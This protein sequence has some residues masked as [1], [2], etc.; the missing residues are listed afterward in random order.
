MPVGSPVDVVIAAAVPVPD[1]LGLD[2]T[3][4]DK[5][6]TAAGLRHAVA[7][8]K[9]SNRPSGT[10]LGQQPTS[11]SL[12][13]LGTQVRLTVARHVPAKAVGGAILALVGGVGLIIRGRR[14]GRQ[15]SERQAGGQGPVVK[16]VSHFDSG[17]RKF[18]ADHPPSLDVELRFR[19]VADEGERRIEAARPL[20]E[21]DGDA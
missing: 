6:L 2:R 16:V 3:D 5:R 11:D 9:L 1:V 17:S 4:A 8:T 19:A 18:E 13:P 14:R 12:V 15:R 10:V 7:G 20:L 21:E